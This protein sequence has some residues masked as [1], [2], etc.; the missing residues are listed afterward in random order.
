[1][2]WTLHL[3]KQ[4]PQWPWCPHHAMWA[5]VWWSLS[6]VSAFIHFHLRLIHVLHLHFLWCGVQEFGHSYQCQWIWANPR[7]VIVGVQ[8]LL[9]CPIC[10]AS[11]R[12]PLVWSGTEHQQSGLSFGGSSSCAWLLDCSQQFTHG[13]VYCLAPPRLTQFLPT[14]VH[15]GCL[16]TASELISQ[17]LAPDDCVYCSIIHFPCLLAIAIAL[18]Q[19][20]SLHRLWQG[21]G[22]L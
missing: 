8:N 13:S 2:W 3:W 7:V 18:N 21:D 17:L 12:L 20:I 5:M 14:D 19:L 4:S 16:G 22:L 6:W 15:K 9:V 11:T 1:M 10:L